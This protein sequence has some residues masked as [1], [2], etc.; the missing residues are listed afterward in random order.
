MRRLRSHISRNFE[1][2]RYIHEVIQEKLREDANRFS[3]CNRFLRLKATLLKS[4]PT[5]PSRRLRSIIFPSRLVARSTP[6]LLSFELGPVS[7]VLTQHDNGSFLRVR[8]NQI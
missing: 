5:L 3:G 4:D 1:K 8:S 6:S 7:S 2:R